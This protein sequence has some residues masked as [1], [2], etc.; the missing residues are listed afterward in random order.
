MANHKKGDV[1]DLENDSFIAEFDTIAARQ[2][3]SVA[4]QDSIGNSLSWSET[5]FRSIALERTLSKL[6][7][8]SHSRI[9]VFQEPT[10]DWIYSLLGIWRA[11]HTYVPLETTQGLRRLTD[12]AKEANLAAV[13]IHDATIPLISQLGLSDEVSMVNVST[14]PSTL[15]STALAPPKVELGHEAMIIYTSGSTGVPKVFFGV[16]VNSLLELSI[17]RV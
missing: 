14:L 10:V 3:A 2:P 1:L 13:V 17:F 7:L 12:V 16:F 5:A 9:G 11:G 4:L 8:P 15:Q 6:R